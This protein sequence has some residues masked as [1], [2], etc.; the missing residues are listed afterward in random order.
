MVKGNTGRQQSKQNTSRSMRTGGS[1]QFFN[2][3]IIHY[4]HPRLSL[5][6]FMSRG[7]KAPKEGNIA[8]SGRLLH[9]RRNYSQPRHQDFGSNSRRNC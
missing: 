9:F 7:Y 6:V 5:K 2:T 3:T 8:H 1:E 4:M